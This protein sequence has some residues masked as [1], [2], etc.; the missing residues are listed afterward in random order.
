MRQKGGHMIPLSMQGMGQNVGRERNLCVIESSSLRSHCNGIDIRLR[1]ILR[2]ST[3]PPKSCTLQQSLKPWNNY[4]TISTKGKK[5]QKLQH[6]VTLKRT[7][8][9]H[10]SAIS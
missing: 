10:S 2:V 7:E 1:W 9:R 6:G 8:E 5:L 3:P 4:K